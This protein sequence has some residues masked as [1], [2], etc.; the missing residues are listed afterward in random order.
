[1]N[2][3]LITIT[4]WLS[5]N[6]GL[7]ANYEPPKVA[8]VDIDAVTAKKYPGLLGQGSAAVGSQTRNEF[9]VIAFYDIPEHTIYLPKTWT[10]K[11]PAESSVLVHEMV[12]HLQSLADMKY[13]C[14][15]AQEQLAYEAQE[16]WLNTMGRSIYTEF[17]IDKFSLLVFTHCMGE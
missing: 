14:P 10:G 6:F 9:N 3:L 8:C 16:K 5:L 15:E 2:A 12:H 4:L 13:P 1:M 11:T 17:E 7:P